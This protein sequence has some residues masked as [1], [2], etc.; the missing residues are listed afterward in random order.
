MRVVDR[1]VLLYAVNPRAPLH[2]RAWSA[3][4]AALAVENG[5]EVVSF[6]RDYQRFQR[7]RSSVP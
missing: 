5:A 6:D 7:V 2:E 4:L 1:D 3:H